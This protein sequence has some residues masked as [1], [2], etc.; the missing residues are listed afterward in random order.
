MNILIIRI[1]K[2]CVLRFT[3]SELFENCCFIA[4]REKPLGF[5]RYY[6]A[7]ARFPAHNIHFLGILAFHRHIACRGFQ[8]AFLIPL[9]HLLLLI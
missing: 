4:K 3:Q 1:L 7:A 6:L 8:I 5:S 9:V 2:I